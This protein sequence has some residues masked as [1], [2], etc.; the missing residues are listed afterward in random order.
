ME[1]VTIFSAFNLAEAQL[2]RS[3][4]EA[5]DFHPFLANENSASWLVGYSTATTVRV[6]VPENE[7]SDATE[8]LQSPSK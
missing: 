4:L 2:V 1:M 3:R 6:Q 8:F 7:A 5:A